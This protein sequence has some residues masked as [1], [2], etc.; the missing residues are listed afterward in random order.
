MY[1]IARRD[2]CYGEICQKTCS[3]T[4]SRVQRVSLAPSVKS[5]RNFDSLPGS[6]TSVTCNNSLP[7]NHDVDQLFF[8]IQ[9]IDKTYLSH[10]QFPTLL[11]FERRIHGFS[12]QCRLLLFT[13]TRWLWGEYITVHERRDGAGKCKGGELRMYVFISAY[14]CLNEPRQ[15]AASSAESA[16]M[17][18]PIHWTGDSARTGIHQVRKK[19]TDA[20]TNRSDLLFSGADGST[21]TPTA[22]SSPLPICFPGAL[23]LPVI[24]SENG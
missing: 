22:F 23:D 2:R 17:M 11:D 13:A 21:A 3:S 19:A 5:R 14:L 15:V 10:V 24:R 6:V 1:H 20:P 4:R 18:L 7:T 9:L 8:S 16:H 12:G